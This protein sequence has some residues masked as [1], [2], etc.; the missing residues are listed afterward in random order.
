MSGSVHELPARLLE[1]RA[2]F[3]SHA[4][5][6]YAPEH[7]LKGYLECAG[8]D[9]VVSRFSLL[10]CSIAL[11]VLAADAPPIGADGVAQELTRLKT[12]AKKSASGFSSAPL[13]AIDDAA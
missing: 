10:T 3:A 11:L 9:G 12:A 13:S 6:L 4:E 2:R 7:R 8:R 5:S 1:M